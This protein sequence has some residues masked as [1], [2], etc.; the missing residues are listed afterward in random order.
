MSKA[1]DDLRRL[2]TPD[3]AKTL[4]QSH[5]HGAQ[6]QR[7]RAECERRLR[8]W[9]RVANAASAAILICLV[10]TVLAQWWR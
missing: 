1:C 5:G 10:L 3:L 7:A 2:T 6:S 4:A 8:Q 9:G